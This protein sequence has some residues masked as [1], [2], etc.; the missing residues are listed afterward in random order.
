M[1]HARI[2][3]FFFCTRATLRTLAIIDFS[4]FLPFPPRTRPET[5]IWG[6]K[7]QIALFALTV[8]LGLRLGLARAEDGTRVLFELTTRMN[9]SCL[10]NCG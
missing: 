5:P 3:F 4:S 10:P 6:L 9:H 8:Q 7:S 1:I 2:S